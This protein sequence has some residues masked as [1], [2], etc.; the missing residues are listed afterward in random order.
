MRPS[1]ICDPESLH[2]GRLNKVLN[3]KVFIRVSVEE[4]RR[5]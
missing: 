3:F 4:K 2:N 1:R 5:K